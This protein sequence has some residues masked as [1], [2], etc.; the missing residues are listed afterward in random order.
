MCIFIVRVTSTND[1]HLSLEIF[2]TRKH[3]F[4]FVYGRN[5]FFPC[6]NPTA[7]GGYSFNSDFVEQFEAICVFKECK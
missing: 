7:K 5:Y 4:M 2:K 3:I 6:K 1:Y